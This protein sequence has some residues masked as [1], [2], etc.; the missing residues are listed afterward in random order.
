[1]SLDVDAWLQSI[2]FTE[3]REP[4]RANDIDAALLPKLTDADLS[5]CN[6]VSSCLF[7]D[8]IPSRFTRADTPGYRNTFEQR[9]IRGYTA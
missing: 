3:L 9:S 1:M 2:G 4:F 5:G 6:G 7:V 8:P